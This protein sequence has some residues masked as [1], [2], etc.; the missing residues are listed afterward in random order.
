M[1]DEGGD[2]GG[3]RL[4]TGAGA[5][6]A[7]RATAGDLL[8]RRDPGG[9]DGSRG[10]GRGGRVAPVRPAVQGRRP[11][12]VRT[13]P[14]GGVRD[15]AS[16]LRPVPGHG[17]GQ[18]AGP[19]RGAADA[20]AV[21]GG[22][23]VRAAGGT[24]GSAAGPGRGALRALAAARSR[25]APAPAAPRVPAVDQSDTPGLP[26]LPHAAAVVRRLSE[27]LP[28]TTVLTGAQATREKLLNSLPDHPYLHFSGHG[29]QDPT[30]SSGGALYLHD[31]ER[32]GPL[33]VAD[34]SRL[35]LADA[36]LAY[37]SAC[38]TARGAATLPDEA[39]HLAGTLQL[40]GFTHVV[41]AQWAVDDARALRVADTFY[42][43]LTTPGDGIAPDRAAH[44][45]HTAVQYLRRRNSD[46]LW[47]AAYVHTGP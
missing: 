4:G 13:R 42:A 21:R 20:D 8:D 3:Q 1:A 41:A 15:R 11:E 33:T 10:G 6:G 46:P 29:T 39:A 26:P 22:R 36:R 38:E 17:P 45:L 18:R 43:G 30:D 2:A 40:A 32:S 7:A 31:H 12:A 37:L 16:A 34:I 27:R 23:P 9:G 24:G 25:P 35:R 28:R 47:W 14:V 5:R 19:A 44:A